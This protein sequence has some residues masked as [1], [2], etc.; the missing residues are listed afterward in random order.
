MSNTKDNNKLVLDTLYRHSFVFILAFVLILGSAAVLW[1][2]H[3]K[4]KELNQRSAVVDAKDFASSVSQFR[5]FYSKT[6]VPAARSQGMKISHDYI[7][8]DDSIPLPATFAKDF[9]QSLSLS[10]SAYTVKLFS[11]KPFPW[12]KDQKLDKF[13]KIALA[14][15]Q[16]TPNQPIWSFETLDG[17]L[18]LRYARG[19]VLKENC[20]ACHNS[21]SGTPKTDWK[22]GDVRGVLEVIR[23]ISAFETESSIVL[24]NSFL[25]MLALIL[26]MVL[27]IFFVLRKLSRSIKSTYDAYVKEEKLTKELK[28]SDVKMHAIVDSVQEVIIVLDKNGFIQESNYAIQSMFG[29]DQQDIVGK[30]I[31][32]L[33]EDN[34]VEDPQHLIR[35]I[36]GNRKEVIGIHNNK[37]K[38]SIELFVNEAN[39]DNQTIYTAS[40]RDISH[41]KKAEEVTAQA[42]KTALESAEL[43]SE[44][45]ANMSHEIRTPMNGVIGMTELLLHSKL[46][47]DQKD[48]AGTVKESADSLLTIINDILD[49]SKIE[50]GKLSI[51]KSPFDLL[52]MVEGSLSL[53]SKDADHKNV[54]MTFFIDGN[55]PMEITQDAG[56]L[57][58]V[59]INLCNNA[60]KFTENGNIIIHISMADNQNLHFSVIDTGI[61]IPK[62]SQNNLFDSFSQV[63]GSN[64]REH[65]GTGLGL[66]ICKQLINL[67]DGEIG[68][69][70]ELH[71]GST[72]WFTI[73][74]DP[75]EE[76]IK[77]YIY[78]N[79]SVLMMSSSDLLNR[80]YNK[81]L[82]HWGMKST[83][84]KKF[85]DLTEMIDNNSY[86]MLCIDT[87]NIYID[88]QNPESL[89]QVINTIQVK[90]EAILVLYASRKQFKKIKQIESYQD[91]EFE[92]DK[93]IY[94]FEK[95]VK[96]TAIKSLL[97]QLSKQKRS[98][99][100]KTLENKETEKSSNKIL[101]S[102]EN[103]SINEPSKKHTVDNNVRETPFHI[104]VAE[105]NLVNQKVA[106]VMLKKL[107]YQVSIAEN[108]EEAYDKAN[109]SYF[110]AILMDCQMPV[111]DGYEATKQIRA[112]ASS[113]FNVDIPIIAF[114]AHAMKDDDNVCKEAGMDDY[115]SKPV[116]LDALNKVFEQ[117]FDSL[118]ERQEK[119]LAKQKI[120][121]E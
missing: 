35:D 39:R 73:K 92:L 34:I 81:Q 22:A 12:R 25:T 72:F 71:V 82:T 38:F 56:R 88:E 19:D 41:F 68:V 40:L 104:L 27:L 55:V 13:Q 20:V 116:T 66:A 37:D 47:A 36:V 48:L 110:D 16:Q 117:R 97:Y 78:G 105:D 96:H 6:I 106:M 3:Q 101:M 119:Y 23:P 50:A 85:N 77:P 74:I 67:M 102:N 4:T 2:T 51:V 61:G 120:K 98:L 7:G 43:K 45:L 31:T 90:S 108:G 30:N 11:D 28:A 21:Y 18:V 103:I 59:L 63:D 69:H 76:T 17:I 91:L 42:H 58:Q 115:L 46:D 100:Q 79:N 32:L 24:K 114:T 95:P 33:L 64:S 113:H 49:F 93:G 65:G 75:F 8:K 111:M 87:D 44:F 83:I 112:L 107:G 84:V 94:L 54:E 1:N 86:D 60:L 80:Y 121:R 89:L 70:S 53:L 15:I 26:S 10:N 62:E 5:N 99:E 52:K 14:K 9:G 29:Y 57:R 118:Q 109:E